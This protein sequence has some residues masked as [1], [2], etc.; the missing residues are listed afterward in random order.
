[1]HPWHQVDHQHRGCPE[2]RKRRR[3][4]MPG[5][6]E[7]EAEGQG[8]IECHLQQDQQHQQGRGDRAHHGHLGDLRCHEHPGDRFHPGEEE[9]G[10]RAVSTRAA[11]KPPTWLMSPSIHSSF[12][13][14]AKPGE[15]PTCL[16]WGRPHLPH[17]P[18]QQRAHSTSGLLISGPREEP[19]QC[20]VPPSH[21]PALPV[22][23]S[24]S[25][26]GRCHLA[27]DGRAGPTLAPAAPGKPGGPAGPVGP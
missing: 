26:P 15:T 14:E 7:C 25:Q 21:H 18:R 12:S 5:P 6:A 10:G 1:M 23:T 16:G 22:S 9:E 11:P 24:F 3:R 2:E 4:V 8:A 27:G 17:C 19:S 13:T 20:S